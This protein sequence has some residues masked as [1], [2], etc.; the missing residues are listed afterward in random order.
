MQ[1]QGVGRRTIQGQGCMLIIVGMLLACI[2]LVLAPTGYA[3]YRYRAAQVYSGDLSVSGGHA[4]LPIQRADSYTITIQPQSSAP[5]GVTLGFTVQDGFGRTLLSS[6]DFY[7]TGCLADSPANQTCPAQS[8][9]FTFH[10]S[11]GG[12]VQLTLASTQSNLAVV[13][14][15][16]DQDQGGIFANGS[17]I[18]F[19]AFL[20]CGSL[21]WIM[22]VAVLI[23]LA[24]RLERNQVHQQRAAPTQKAVSSA[25]QNDT[26]E[27][28]PDEPEPASPETA[29]EDT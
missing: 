26:P 13:V 5:G 24:R 22:V 11:L 27:P 7:T 14:Q 25:A 1:Q 28:P 21:L 3:F 10:N 17:P 23:V 20:G 6:T 29:E 15:V 4:T 12:P 18:L 8:R 2:L 16:R 19:G 9:D